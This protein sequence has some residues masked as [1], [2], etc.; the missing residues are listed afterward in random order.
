MSNPASVWEGQTPPY[1]SQFKWEYKYRISLIHWIMTIGGANT[2]LLDVG[3]LQGQYAKKLRAMGYAG[4]YKGVDLAPT[5]VD[6]AKREN[7]KECFEVGNIHALSD[8][9]AS[10]DIV[11]CAHVIDH[12][13]HIGKPF[14]ELFRVAGQYVIVSL[15]CSRGASR[16]SQDCD[17]IN[18]YY[19]IADI[20]AAVP[21]GWRSVQSAIFTPEWE[22]TTDIF[23]CVWQRVKA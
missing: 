20:F 1:G 16:I 17:F 12:L 9:D 22:A 11:L 18:H 14:S 13:F 3:C 6:A 19:S 23:Q 2:S 15:M 10:F 7:P 4:K 21:A 8:K 5:F